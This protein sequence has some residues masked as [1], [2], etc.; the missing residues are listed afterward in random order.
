MTLRRRLGSAS[1]VALTFV[2][3]GPL[4]ALAQPFAYTFGTTEIGQINQGIL[5]YDDG[6]ESFT[7]ALV[8]ND[9]SSTRFGV[10]STSPLGSEWELFSNL[11]AEWQPRA[12]NNVNQ[13]DEDLYDGSFDNGNI[14][15][16]EA[17][18]ENERFGRFWIGQ[19]SMASDGIAEVDL[20]GTGVIAYVSVAD[21][22]GGQFFRQEDGTLSDIDV[23]DVFSSLDGLSRKVRIRYD[24]PEFN[25]FQLKTSYGRDLLSDDEDTR[26][27]NLFDLAVTY[28]GEFETFE[29]EAA[30]GIGREDPPDGDSFD[31]FSGSV[32]G[33]HT[34]TGLN[35]TL[36]AGTE[37]TDP[38]PSYGYVK[39]GWF[40]DFFEFGSSNFSIDYYGGQDFEVDGS[41]SQSYGFGAVQNFGRQQ[42][43][44]TVRNY[45][46]DEDAVDYDDGMAIFGGARI[47][48]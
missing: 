5:Q 4:P 24:T 6:G 13:L 39:L 35:L 20:S 26:D 40:R 44:F 12:S 48:F 45:A 46:F 19:G 36:A 33:V 32:S 42:I 30:A 18:F 14:R 3:V 37:T 28:A 17:R 29:I 27:T 38:E 23:G 22:A 10:R 2:W 11:E 7:Y 9:N 8:D 47:R 15:K 34:P 31:V 16:I 43:W 41:E 21:T 1:A 25:G